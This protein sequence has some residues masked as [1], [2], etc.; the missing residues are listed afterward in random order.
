MQ[1]A[2]PP[3]LLRV[4]MPRRFMELAGTVQQQSQGCLAEH[5]VQA[6][7]DT[8]AMD[9]AAVGMVTAVAECE[10]DDVVPADP[11]SLPVD[12]PDEP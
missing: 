10:S 6:V 12:M 4:I 5:G 7:H 9:I 3:A 8:N 2:F 11:G 1:G